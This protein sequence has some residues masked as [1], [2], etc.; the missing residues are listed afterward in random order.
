MG[1]PLQ[2]L[3]KTPGS[4]KVIR[5]DPFSIL[6]PQG[7]LCENQGGQTVKDE[8]TTESMRKEQS[9]GGPKKGIAKG[10]GNRRRRINEKNKPQ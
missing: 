3:E 10:E 5:M 8:L 1:S 2:L 9:K 7:C 6:N 4:H